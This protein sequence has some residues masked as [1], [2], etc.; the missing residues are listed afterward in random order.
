MHDVPV[1]EGFRGLHLAL[2]VLELFVPAR[3]FAQEHDL[4]GD[5]IPS[6]GES[7]E[8]DLAHAPRAEFP[9]DVD[10]RKRRK[11][12]RLAR[13]GGRG[14]DRLGVLDDHL[15][16]RLPGGDPVAVL[17]RDSFGLLRL[18]LPALS[19]LAGSVADPVDIGSVQA[20]QVQ[21][22]AFGRVDLQKKMVLGQIGVARNGAVALRGTPQNE[23]IVVVEDEFPG[24]GKVARHPEEDP[25]HQA[26]RV[27]LSASRNSRAPKILFPGS[28]DKARATSSSTPPPRSSGR[29][30]LGAA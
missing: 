10:S 8:I 19:L 5:P 28:A 7:A 12:P 24:R 13:G 6:A 16:L 23:D 18:L 3:S 2:E 27:C 15:K 11:G 9:L 29:I 14:P 25:R 4:H 1:L 30:V 20:S 21:Q 17:D 22:D 26:P